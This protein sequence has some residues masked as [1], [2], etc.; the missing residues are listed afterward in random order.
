MSQQPYPG[1]P[2]SQPEM[3][4]GRE[5]R[6]NEL[7]HLDSILRKRRMELQ[8][9][10]ADL[11]EHRHE[12][13]AVISQCKRSEERMRRAEED[14]GAL[15]TRASETSSELIRA[16]NQLLSLDIKTRGMT[17]KL[18]QITAEVDLKKKELLEAEQSLVKVRKDSDGVMTSVEERTRELK[19]LESRLAGTEERLRLYLKLEDLREVVA[20]TEREEHAKHERRVSALKDGEKIIEERT[21]QLARTHNEL[22]KQT[23][24][25]HELNTCIARARKDLSELELAMATRRREIEE[26]GLRREKEREYHEGVLQQT[27]DRLTEVNDARNEALE[28]LR[29]HRAELMSMRERVQEESEKLSM[30]ERE[31]GNKER[32]IEGLTARVAGKEEELVSLKEKTLEAGI[33]LE[34]VVSEI[35]RERGLLKKTEEDRSKFESEMSELAA[36]KQE[37]QDEIQELEQDQDRIKGELVS[38]KKQV[39]SA[40]A[41]RDR[42]QSDNKTSHQELDVVK[43]EL[44]DQKQELESL[45]NS[46]SKVTA[47][48]N[49][50][51]KK[52][53]ETKQNHAEFE[54]EFRKLRDELEHR[55]DELEQLLQ[56]GETTRHSTPAEHMR[57]EP[58]KRSATAIGSKEV[59]EKR[60]RRR[61]AQ[62]PV[63]K[64]HDVSNVANGNE[65]ISNSKKYVDEAGTAIEVSQQSSGTAVSSIKCSQET[66]TGHAQSD[67]ER[68]VDELK[69][70]NKQMRQSL[71]KSLLEI[72][73][74]KEDLKKQQ[75]TAEQA[76]RSLKVSGAKSKEYKHKL[77]QTVKEHAQEQTRLAR[78]MEFFRSE[79]QHHFGHAQKLAQ[80]L[81]LYKQKHEREKNEN[82]EDKKKNAKKDIEDQTSQ[83]KELVKS[84]KLVETTRDQTL[85]EIKQL[86]QTKES[87][88]LQLEEL[89]HSIK[90]T[91]E[92][93]LEAQKIGMEAAK[94]NKDDVNRK[95]SAEKIKLQQGQLR[96]QLRQQMTKRAELLEEERRKAGQSLEGLKSKLKNLEQV[97]T[98]KDSTVQ[99][100]RIELAKSRLD[101]EKV[102][103]ME[104]ELNEL[105]HKLQQV[106]DERDMALVQRDHLA[107]LGKETAHLRQPAARP[108]DTLA[109]QDRPRTQ[110]LTRPEVREGAEIALLL[111]TLRRAA[112]EH[113]RK[114]RT[115]GRERRG[116]EERIYHEGRR[117]GK[118]LG[119]VLDVRDLASEASSTMDSE[120][121]QSSVNASPFR[122]LH[123][124]GNSKRSHSGE[125]N[126]NSLEIG[127]MGSKAQ[128]RYSVS[129]NNS[130][131]SP[132]KEKTRRD[133]DKDQYSSP[134]S[135]YRPKNYKS[136]WRDINETGSPP[137]QAPMTIGKSALVGTPSRKGPDESGSVSSSQKKGRGRVDLER[138]KT[139]GFLS[140]S[141]L[142]DDKRTRFLASVNQ[143]KNEK[144]RELEKGMQHFYQQ[145]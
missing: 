64:K 23:A 133:I 80:E 15:E 124:Q 105:K 120:S 44:K 136:P 27:A 116:R 57:D 65:R 79:A 128:S 13:D 50:E 77:E 91:S 18:T 76:Q 118:R 110:P 125:S 97:I 68:T 93:T 7:T 72:K 96:D 48:L 4:A 132:E 135:S 33:E 89:R 88:M 122:K 87:M 73:K 100:F 114:P 70:Q 8:E 106:Q 129:R 98:R 53:S 75:A 94:Q 17:E 109:N 39:V 46:K 107:T 69:G 28:A 119:R 24:E 3:E 112:L 66:R 62:L 6:M 12:L 139:L 145:R 71:K 14:A 51:K 40:C 74:L 26:Q 38:L 111:E 95:M 22:Q 55:R 81:M 59:E 141:S 60:K 52:F 30:Y 32:E 10:T 25:Y 41:D 99:D 102:T 45:V 54:A 130:Q 117:E 108:E 78:E 43:Q 140:V 83:I 92:K 21:T 2:V 16:G 37:L 82:M 56:K 49:L 63:P 31:T 11:A 36:R 42:V 20:A 113:G 101:K 115:E 138:E 90:E 5:F 126:C 85:E 67:L 131:D 34:S 123:T 19:S 47:D 134:L 1:Y 142:A 61:G 127:T 84:L 29:K 144:M 58:A 104:N 35:N 137:P 86:Q 143:L 103:E 9:V 121:E